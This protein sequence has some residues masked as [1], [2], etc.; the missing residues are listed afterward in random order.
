MFSLEAV[1]SGI[2]DHIS[3]RKPYVVYTSANL[4]AIPIIKKDR[5]FWRSLNDADMITFDGMAAIWLAH[6]S[7]KKK[8]KKIGADRLMRGLY[9]MAEDR[10]WSFY[11]LGN[12][13]GVAEK[14]AK[15]IKERFPNLT[16]AG[17]HNGYF[18]AEE[19]R[20]II[21]EINRLSPDIL[22][23][24]L[25]MPYQEKWIYKNKKML[26]AGLITNCGSYLEQTANSGID[27]Y[28]N[29]TYKYSLNWFYRFK[30]DPGRLWKRYL[31][32]GI[33]F[34]PDLSG[35]LFRY[36]W[37]NSVRLWKKTFMKRKNDSKA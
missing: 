17:M 3:L 24:G 1:L 36:I 31:L 34:L 23:V 5:E 2:A 18:D 21:R 10:G 16:I 33:A 7:G 26:R 28:P 15:K 27:Y 20:E 19:E 32:D 35:A 22:A 8:A 37:T 30:N 4:H 29:W 14:A 6:L 12:A 25:G 11:F 13:K 9:S